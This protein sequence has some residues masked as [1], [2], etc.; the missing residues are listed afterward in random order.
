V[1]SETA[2]GTDLSK[3]EN[4]YVLKKEIPATMK[5]AYGQLLS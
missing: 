4:L 5:E 1:K 2:G 3:R